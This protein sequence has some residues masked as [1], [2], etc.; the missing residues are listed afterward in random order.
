MVKP[1]RIALLTFLP[2]SALVA[3]LFIYLPAAGVGVSAVPRALGQVQLPVHGWTI[4]GDQ[5][6]GPVPGV[7]GSV[8]RLDICHGSG[9]EVRAYCLDPGQPVPPNGTV[10]SMV[11]STDFWCGGGFQEL[12]QYQILQTPGAPTP[13]PSLTPTTS[14]TP[15]S[16]PTTSPTP[17]Q[18]GTTPPAPTLTPPASTQTLTP[19]VFVRPSPGGPG[20]LPLVLSTIATSAGVLLL[21][22]FAVVTSHINRKR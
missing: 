22:A 1:L 20:N 13:Q 21:L 14:P 4:C 10:C 11:N 8:Q 9:W 19:T 18:P 16:S 5:G 12:R 6:I 15:Q 2:L 3:A 7:P 17:T